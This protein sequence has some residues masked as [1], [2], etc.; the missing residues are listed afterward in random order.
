MDSIQG[1]RKERALQQGIIS[2]RKGEKLMTRF[3]KRN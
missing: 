3:Y 2:D 1:T